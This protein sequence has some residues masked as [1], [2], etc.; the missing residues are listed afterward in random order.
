MNKYGKQ[1]QNLFLLDFGMSL[2]LVLNYE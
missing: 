2:P 1:N